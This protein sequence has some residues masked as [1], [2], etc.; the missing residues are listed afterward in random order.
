MP[1]KPSRAFGGSGP[2]D[3]SRTI[4]VLTSCTSR[5]D[6]AAS[7]GRL[8]AERLYI[9]EQHRRLMCGVRAVRNVP[10]GF[11][12]D[13]RILSAGHGIVS[14]S[15]RLGIYDASFS[16]LGGPAIDAIAE[17]LRV[18]A[19]L[20][21]LLRREH[22]LTLLLL[23]EDYMRAAGIDSATVLGGP[24]IAFGGRWLM[25][26]RDELPLRVVPAGR[27]EARRFSCGVIGLKGELA[28]RLL[29]LIAREPELVDRLA[30]PDTDIL[31]MLESVH[32]DADLAAA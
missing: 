9:G 29:G 8:A 24:T 27:E 4:L 7:S 25:R 16:G 30:D 17:Q 28:G 26:R 18:R 13:L 3:R 14:G 23:G 10:S 20:Q 19:S 1:T 31:A 22:L 11:D 15:R 2:M 5:K 21:R 12:I 32:S 6:L